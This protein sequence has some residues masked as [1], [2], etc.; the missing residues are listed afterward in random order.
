MIMFVSAALDKYLDIIHIIILMPN[1]FCHAQHT[2]AYLNLRV[3]V[4]PLGQARMT[5]KH[6]ESDALPIA[7]A[8]PGTAAP[9]HQRR[10]EEAQP[11]L[12]ASARSSLMNCVSENS[13][14]NGRLTQSKPLQKRKQAPNV[15][16]PQKA[17]QQ[18][19]VYN[20]FSTSTE[21]TT[22]SD[23]TMPAVGD[24]H[25]VSLQ[26]LFAH[27]TEIPSLQQQQQQQQDTPASKACMP[28]TAS[29]VKHHTTVSFSSKGPQRLATEHAQEQGHHSQARPDRKAPAK[30]KANSHAR[31]AAHSQARADGT[32]RSLKKG[33]QTLR[34]TADRAAESQKLP[35]TRLI[36]HPEVQSH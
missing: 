8:R 17:K 35:T 2:Q 12:R 36:E 33:Q 26:R 5:G 1:I 10:L 9:S 14:A 4:L 15:V 6:P 7:C 20:E 13:K 24:T 3:Q 32:R 27:D 22:D 25:D 18:K 34:M 19:L 11:R 21:G 31:N 23:C 30:L 16:Q 29:A 28:L